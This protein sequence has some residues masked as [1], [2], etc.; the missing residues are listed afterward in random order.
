MPQALKEAFRVLKPGGSIY[1]SVWKD[2]KFIEWVQ[3]AS[4]KTFGSRIALTVNPKVW[5]SSS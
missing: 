4:E 1:I 2:L 5:P 3:Q